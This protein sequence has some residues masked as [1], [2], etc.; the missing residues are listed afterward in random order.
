VN[1]TRRSMLLAVPAAV[2]VACDKGNST[3]EQAAPLETPP[4]LGP[5]ISP[6]ELA[7]RLD[8]VKSGRVAVLYVGP[9]M[10][11]DQARVPGA[12]RLP[13]AGTDAGYQALVAQIAATPKDTEIVVYCGCCPYRSCQNVR[14]A[15]KAIR[16]SGRTNAKY[17]DIPTNF[18]TDWIKPGFPVERG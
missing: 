18:R 6:A 14:P 9:D 5:M 1:L 16:A 12:R 13:E 2:M 10:L 7:K 15:S 11:F 8:E 17:L 4:P 3:G